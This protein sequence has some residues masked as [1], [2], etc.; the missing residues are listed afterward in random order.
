MEFGTC[1]HGPLQ[2]SREKPWL[3]KGSKAH[4][5]LRK[6]VLDKRLLNSVP[7][8]LNFRYCIVQLQFAMHNDCS[9]L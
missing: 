1:Y 8:Y 2:E 6:I 7:Y 4:D 3:K 5:A 9:N